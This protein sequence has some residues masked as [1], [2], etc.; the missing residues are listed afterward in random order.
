M[1][2]RTS[3]CFQTRSCLS[4]SSRSA[5]AESWD[6][7]TVAECAYADH[8]W[9]LSFLLLSVVAP[10]QLHV[11]PGGRVAHDVGEEPEGLRL[12]LE[13]LT[14]GLQVD[15][16]GLLLGLISFFLL[17]GELDDVLIFGLLNPTNFRF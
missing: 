1:A 6:C 16:V 14:Q 10:A 7:R 9:L 4:P 2:V 15:V 12:R 5:R 8:V 13:L 11:V 17:H 3:C